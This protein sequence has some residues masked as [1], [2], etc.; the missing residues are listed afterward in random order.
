MQKFNKGDIIVSD[1]DGNEYEVIKFDTRDNLEP[2]PS[3]SLLGN[4]L[5]VQDSNGKKQ[6]LYEWEVTKK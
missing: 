6:L 1:L 4:G 5:I 2:L 3:V